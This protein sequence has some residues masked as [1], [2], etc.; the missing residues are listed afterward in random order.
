MAL[1]SSAVV[2]LGGS[3]ITLKDRPMTVDGEVLRSIA[4]QLSEYRERGGVLMG[5]VHGGGSFGHYAVRSIV[6]RKGGLEVGDAPQIQ[7]AMISLALMVVRELSSK[8]IKASLHPPHTYCWGGECFLRPL[9][10]DIEVGLVPVTFGDAVPRKN[11]LE[12]VSGDDL[13]YL[14]ARESGSEC[15]VFA[16]RVEGVLR[17]DGS[18]VRILRSLEEFEDLGG[19]DATGGMRRKVEMALRASESGVRRVVIVSGDN[20]L[21]ALLGRE[22]G[23]RVEAVGR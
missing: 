19:V 11:V 21:D 1:C 12:I 3:L 10:R 16:T 23:T 5:V 7:L 9:L 13:A 18:L 22:V 6:E 4:S 2:K 15:L 8:G 17:G 20:L 14:L